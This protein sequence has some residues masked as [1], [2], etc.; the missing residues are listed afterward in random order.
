MVESVRLDLYIYLYVFTIDDF[1][2]LDRKCNCNCTSV[3]ASEP[4]PD[5]SK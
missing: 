3:R 4:S 1:V 2:G 5:T